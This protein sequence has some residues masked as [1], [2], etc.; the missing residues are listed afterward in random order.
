LKKQSFVTI[1]PLVVRGKHGSS[2]ALLVGHKSY[3]TTYTRKSTVYD[4][5]TLPL[6][7]VCRYSKER[8]KRHGVYYFAYIGIGAKVTPGPRIPDPTP[9]F[10]V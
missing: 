10:C 6:H 2:R 3:Q 4:T 7:I 5:E 9:H 8:Y 1:M